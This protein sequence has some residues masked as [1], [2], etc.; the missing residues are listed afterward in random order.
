MAWED[1]DEDFDPSYFEAGEPDE[2]ALEDIRK[3]DERIR[4]MPLMIVAHQILEITEALM[5]TLPT[6]N[7]SEHYKRIMMEDA[8]TLAP[9]IASAEGADL[10]T[11]RMEN[12]VIVKVAARNLLTQ[13]CGL[14]M[15]GLSDDRYLNVL[16]D[17][18][19]LFRLHFID[20]VKSFDKTKD[21]QDNWGLFYD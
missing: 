5:E 6:D 12:A 20:W 19:D 16:R 21:I 17:E 2:E 8:L 7:M 15:M 18:L 9:K 13:T 1:D 10:Y 11:L 3:E 4:K 14:Q